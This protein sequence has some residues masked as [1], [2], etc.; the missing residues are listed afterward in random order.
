[1]KS[2][3]KTDIDEAILKW[4]KILS[5]EEFASKFPLENMKLSIEEKMQ[6]PIAR[7]VAAIWTKLELENKNNKKDENNNDK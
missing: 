2:N 7:K 5:K 1:M 4:K 6:L 3:F